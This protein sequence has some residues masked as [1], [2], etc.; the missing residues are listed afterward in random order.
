MTRVPWSTRI[1][2]AKQRGRFNGADWRDGTAWCDCA[3]AE[4]F[5]E[6][7]RDENGMPLDTHLQELGV[8]FALAVKADEFDEARDVLNKLEHY[9]Q[10]GEK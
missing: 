8:D 6:F 5:P 4:Q 9:A 3:V 1:A 7:E 10:T 2:L